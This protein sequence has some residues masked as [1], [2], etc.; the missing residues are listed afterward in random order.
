[1]RKC[2]ILFCMSAIRV[3]SFK[4][5][6]QHFMQLYLDMGKDKIQE[7][8]IAFLNSVTSI[9]PFLELDQSSLNDFNLCLSSFLMDQTPVIFEITS[10][11]DMKLLKLKRSINQGLL[12][13]DEAVKQEH[14]QRLQERDTFEIEVRMTSDDS[15]N[16][17]SI[18]GSSI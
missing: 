18:E 1:M 7:V 2:F 17:N 3:L 13:E 15:K 4:T 16:K 10:S 9:R 14:E 8:R 11:L 6:K 12:I 5:F